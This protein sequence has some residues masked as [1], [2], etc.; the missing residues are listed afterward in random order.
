L[1]LLFVGADFQRKGGDMVVDVVRRLAGEVEAD[2]VTPAEALDVPGIRVHR[3]GPNSPELRAL[4]ARA[5]VFVLPSRAECFGIAAVEALASG[6]PVLMSNVGGSADIVDD[7][8]NGWRIDPTADGLA[9]AIEA[10]LAQR[11][12]LPA[13]GRAARASAEV[14]FDGRKN[15]RAVLDLMEGLLQEQPAQTQPRLEQRI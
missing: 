13:M 7:G 9:T 14:K 15:D 2:M 12:R 3:A 1:R 4:F 6:L 8:I 5:D 11:D 10:V